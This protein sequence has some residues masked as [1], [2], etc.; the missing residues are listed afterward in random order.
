[1]K[2]VF[3]EG[4]KEFEEQ[5]LAPKSKEQTALLVEELEYH[6]GRGGFEYVDNHRYAR[7][8][9]EEEMSA[10]NEKIRRGCCGQFD[11]GFT[12]R[13]VRYTVGCNYGH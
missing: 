12:Y 10:Y 3:K 8:D 13:G 9:N 4:S 11:W 2:N 1:M 5:V 6:I 7:A